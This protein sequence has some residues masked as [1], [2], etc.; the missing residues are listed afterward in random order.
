MIK[1]NLED[2][3]VSE[4]SGS[5]TS[6]IDVIFT[7]IAFMMLMINA[8]LLTMDMDLPDAKKTSIVKAVEKESVTLAVL[9]QE[10]QWR[11]DDGSIVD[12]QTIKQ[13]LSDLNQANDGQLHVLITTDKTTYVQRMVDTISILNELNIQD[14]QIAI[15]QVKT[16]KL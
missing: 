11:L 1:P 3:L 7:L 16:Q 8:P 13:Q 5:M 4:E 14:S 2:D 9:Q 10:N 12:S 6:M 15:N